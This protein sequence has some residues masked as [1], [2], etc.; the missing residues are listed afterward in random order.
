MAATDEIKRGSDST[1]NLTLCDSDGV[2]I[3]ISTLSGIVAEVYQI[4]NS[5]EQFSLNTQAG[6]TD[7]VIVDGPNG[8]IQLNVDGANTRKAKVGKEVLLEVKT[9]AVDLNFPDGTAEIILGPFIIATMVDSQLRK[10]S[11]F[12]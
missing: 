5:I 12:S 6:F 8:K 3:D 10:A 7:I 4:K 2:A 9:Q 1:F 11:T